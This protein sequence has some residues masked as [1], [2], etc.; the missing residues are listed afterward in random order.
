MSGV[1]HPGPTRLD[2]AEYPEH[3]SHEGWKGNGW[4]GPEPDANGNYII[5]AQYTPLEVDPEVPNT[6]KVTFKDGLT[7]ETLDERDVEEA[8]GITEYPN[9]PTHEGYEFTS[10]TIGTPDAD[11]NVTITANYRP[12]E[13]PIEEG[14]TVTWV[15]WNGTALEQRTDVPEGT[16]IPSSDFRG[17]TPTRPSDGTYTYTFTGWSVSVDA[18]GNV[19]YTAQYTPALIYNPGTPSYPSYPSNPS[20]PSTPSN[21][22]TNIPDTNPPLTDTPSGDGGTTITD[23]DVPL[24]GA[25]GLNDVDHFAY[26]I[27]YSDDTVRPLN[28]ITRAE[29]ATIFFRLMTDEYRTSN[30]ATTNDFSDVAA[31]NWFNNAISTCANA[32]ALN[33][34]SDGSFR[35]NANITRAEFAAIAARFLDK[36]QYTDDGTGDFSDTAGHW[37]AKEIRL[38]A[39]AGWIQGSGNK[40]RP[41]D[42]ITRAE[43]MTIVNRMLDRVPDKDHM[44]DTMKKWTDNPEDAWYY[45][46]VQEATNEHAYERDE[47]GVVET[48]TEI[49]TV[50]D[51]KALEEE[52][53][54][55]N[56]R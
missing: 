38:A 29:V 15:N 28:N 45:E 21:P 48:W 9:A 12:V 22:S 25:V 17:S 5:R 30:W 43:V 31:G 33:G 23:Q 7:D 32:G 14:H 54:N 46:A 49:L 19:T 4:S 44:L 2:D 24:A 47:L 8:P 55:A 36:E 26:I 18:N 1:V 13:V 20:T 39:K 11:G 41:N 51:W 50:R 16:D 56:A 35:P 42:Y 34:Y 52:W 27:G 10:W 6:I 37:A 53:A 40:F 3:P